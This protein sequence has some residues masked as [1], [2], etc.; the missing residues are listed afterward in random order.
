M[1]NAEL[2]RWIPD[3]AAPPQ[4]EADLLAAAGVA[5]P[6]PAPQYSRPIGPLPAAQWYH[7]ESHVYQVTCG[8]WQQ[9]YVSAFP[10]R[11]VWERAVR[12]SLDGQVRHVVQ[13]SPA[14]AWAQ[15]RAHTYP[16]HGGRPCP[17]HPAVPAE[18][19]PQEE[20]S[21]YLWP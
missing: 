21:L 5:I 17:C 15:L 2:V 6:A 1:A 12:A 18:P 9:V 16:S 3:C 13:V 8:Q 14:V 20:E 7:G 10:G 4:W 19:E 11:D